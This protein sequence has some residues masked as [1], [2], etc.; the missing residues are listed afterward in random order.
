MVDTVM[1]DKLIRL[2]GKYSILGRMVVIHEDKDDLGRG[3]LS[4]DKTMI[5]N[6]KKHKESIKTGNAGARI[7]CGLIGYAKECFPEE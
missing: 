2:R 5:L 6:R 7:A 4:H 3:G 1:K